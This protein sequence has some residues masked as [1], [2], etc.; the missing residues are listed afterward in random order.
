MVRSASG[1]VRSRRPR[2]GACVA[3]DGDLVAVGQAP[4]LDAGA[5]HPGAVG[6]AE[7]D[8]HEPVALPAHLGVAA[9][10]VGVAT[11]RC[12]TR[13]CARCVTGSSPTLDPARRRAATSEPDRRAARRPPA[14]RWPP[15]TCPVLSAGRR[16]PARRATGPDEAV[17][18]V[19][20]VLA[21]RLGQLADEGLGEG[22]R[23]CSWSA[24][25]E[26][27]GE[28]VGR[29]DAPSR[30]RV[31]SASI[32]RVRRRPSS[33][34]WS[35][36]RK[37]LANTPST[38]RSRR[39]S[40]S[41]SPMVAA[42]LPTAVRSSHGRGPLGYRGP[43]HSG[44]WRNWQTRRIQVPVSERMWGFK[45][46]LAHQVVAGQRH[47]RDPRNRPS[48]T[49]LLPERSELAQTAAVRSRF[50]LDTVAPVPALTLPGRG[51]GTWATLAPV[52]ARH[53]VRVHAPA[54]RHLLRCGRSRPQMRRRPTV[55]V[56]LGLVEQR[57]KAV[58]E[59]L[60]DGATVT[61]VAR[62]YGVSRQTVH[63]WLRA[64]RGR[65]PGRAWSTAARSPAAC[66]H[67]M[68]PEVEARDRRAA[69]G[70]SGLG[71]AHHRP[72]ARAARASMPCRAASSIYRALSATASSTR[73]PGGAS[74]PTT[75][76][77]SGPGRWSCGRW[78]SSAA[79]A[80]PTAPRPTIVTGIDDHS[81]FC[82]SAQV[83]RAGHGPAGLRRP[84]AGHAHPRRA[85]RRS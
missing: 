73:R 47:T 50:M 26:G 11:A 53:P 34:G 25:A 72:P 29:D 40:N 54:G 57:Y 62:R 66:P 30:R 71:A 23:S 12:R 16:R 14:P 41:A 9:A 31:R 67:Q 24:G 68:A 64:L 36:L 60:D 8:D 20:G 58:L 22:L 39:C 63:D 69:P 48:S 61:D 1:T 33:T 6:R 32:S 7:V 70:A 75:S 84:G 81:R 56:E 82:V 49:G 83:V 76:A 28:V 52:P 79:S 78:T 19:A 3:P 13:A 27:D 4:L 37:A 85:R 55:L 46:P 38:R 15:G 43:A 51:S 80:S 21:G 44:E 35:P 18:L 74:G 65:G 42:S 10:D 5:V 17:A 45:S 59:V 77:G 2:S